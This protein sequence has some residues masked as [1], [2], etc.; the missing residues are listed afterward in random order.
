MLG[1]LLT[2]LAE[3]QTPCKS[4]KDSLSTAMQYGRLLSK[5]IILRDSL[6]KVRAVIIEDLKAINVN[7]EIEKDSLKT[8]LSLVEV[9]ISKIDKKL[10]NVQKQRNSLGIFSILLIILLL[11]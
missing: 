3:G 4:C 1:M 9:K 10:K 5:N 6:L 8:V 2:F 11:L 7:S